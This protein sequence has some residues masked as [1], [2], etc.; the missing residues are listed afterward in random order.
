MTETEDRTKF[1]LLTT[2]SLAVPMW[3]EKLRG[4]P[5]DDLSSMA[6]NA[7]KIIA[8]KGDRLFYKVKGETADTFNELAKGIAILSMAPGGVT[9]MG[10][11]FESEK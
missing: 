11:K 9:F 3:V 8:E 6:A 5:S 1:L 7:A 4:L 2:L 10:W